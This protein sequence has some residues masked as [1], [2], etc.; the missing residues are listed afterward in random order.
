[1][2]AQPSLGP[3]RLILFDIDGT[4]LLTNGAGR[5][6]TR[7]AMEEVFGTSAGLD[8][9]HFGGKTDW[10]TLVELLGP[11]GVDDQTIAA[12]MPAYNAAMGRHISQIIDAY[13]VHSLAGARE[14]VSTLRARADVLLGLVTGNVG[15]AA[16]V[17]LSAA[18]FDPAWFPIGAY[19]HEAHARDDLPPLA[20]RRA[21]AHYGRALAPADVIVIGDTPAD[22][23]CARAHG[24]VAVAVTTGFSPR[25]ALLAAQ[26]DHLLDSLAEFMPA[27]A[28]SLL[29]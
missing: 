9:H 7:R 17:K 14:L 26:P 16:A 20:L 4:L 25:E 8:A 28:P 18:G 5:E 2:A 19:G 13:H 21:V 1:M 6:A 22:I 27:L 24:M 10:Q 15:S 3:A 29:A 11:H 12:A 23:G